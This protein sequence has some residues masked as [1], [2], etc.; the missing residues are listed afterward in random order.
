MRDAAKIRVL[1]VSAYRP[2][3]DALRE[4]LEHEGIDVVGE[5]ASVREAVSVARSLRPDVAVLDEMLPDGAALEGC[6]T[7]KA[8]GATTR[9][10]ILSS[11][12]S[13]ASSGV[14]PGDAVFVL[15]QIQGS[16]VPGAIRAA[17]RR[18]AA[19]DRRRA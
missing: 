7:L 19:P 14:L 1:L 3:R 16:D 9:C 12:R 13:R 4:M 17:A 8:T 6:R 10:V 18:H 11:W 5:T 2:L 15:R